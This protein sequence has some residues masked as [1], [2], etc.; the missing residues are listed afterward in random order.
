VAQTLTKVV[1]GQP[2]AMPAATHNAFVDAAVAHK[3]AVETG[4]APLGSAR[5]LSTV[6]VRNSTDSPRARFESLGIGGLAIAEG[7]NPEQF[8]RQP[9]VEGVE[10]QLEHAGRMVVLLEPVE[11]GRLATAV[12]S[13]VVPAMVRMVAER[14][15]F[16]DVDPSRPG[17]L[18]T[19]HRG[20]VELLWV[21]P[22]EDRA[23]PAVALVLA[24]VGSAGPAVRAV[25]T[26]ASEISANRWAYSWIE[27]EWGGSQWLPVVGGVTSDVWGLAY[28]GIENNNSGSGVQGSGVNVDNFPGTFA[29]VPISAGASVELGGPEFAADGTPA[30][31]FDAVNA[32]DGEC[33]G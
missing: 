30:W 22:A 28:N 33:E 25:I 8:A 7:D 13:G 31:H 14:Q 1:T 10:G 2:F 27:A 16:A 12:V 29:I 5:H 6:V 9:V 17:L 21:Q 4:A 26:G 15:R 18:R 32:E 23:D 11:P 3:M 20:A 24:R 19:W